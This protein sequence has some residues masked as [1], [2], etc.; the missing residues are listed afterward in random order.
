MLPRIALCGLAGS[1]KSTAADHLV[2]THRFVR[3]S[4]ASPIKRMVR[5]LLVEAGAGFIEAVE[6]VDG[7]LKE[8]PTPFLCGHSPRYALQSLGTEWGRDIIAPDLWR[9]I[10]LN[11]VRKFGT[12]PV[13]V[14]DLRFPNEAQALRAEGFLIIRIIRT[15]SWTESAHSS[16]QQEFP[17]DITLTNDGLVSDLYAK[18]DRFV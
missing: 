12:H 18:I 5:S 13:V 7:K 6:M 17:V 1:G 10:L 14:D 4:Y 8:L 11:K 15:N 2:R 3:L 16:E 9:R